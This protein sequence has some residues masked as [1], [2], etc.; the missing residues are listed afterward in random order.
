MKKVL[1]FFML[2]FSVFAC[3]SSENTNI[4]YITKENVKFES[5]EKETKDGVILY[6]SAWCSHCNQ[7]I[8]SLIEN[9]NKINKKV[10]V[11][12][13]PYIPNNGKLEIYEKETLEYIKEK[14]LKFDIYLDEKMEI[15]EKFSIKSIPLIFKVENGVSKV[16]EN[17]LEDTELLEYL[18]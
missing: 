16:V 11:I 12:F 13:I 1:I 6:I 7:T 5:I 14:K 17:D 3:S 15:K 9:E 2:I 10:S 18:K 4:K 8:N